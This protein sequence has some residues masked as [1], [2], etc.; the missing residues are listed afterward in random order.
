MIMYVTY[1]EIRIWCDYVNDS[2]IWI[3]CDYVNNSDDGLWNVLPRDVKGWWLYDWQTYMKVM[4][5]VNDSDN[6]L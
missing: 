5:N 6:C 3:W 1:S 2:E 4:Q